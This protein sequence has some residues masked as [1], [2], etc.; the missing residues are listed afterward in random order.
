MDINTIVGR[1]L[2]KKREKR[3]M[4]QEEVAKLLEIPKQNVSAMESGKRT[5]SYA[6][7]GKICELFSITPECMFHLNGHTDM[8]EELLHEEITKMDKSGKA[9][10]YSHAVAI[11]AGKED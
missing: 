11:N 10:L 9:K 7:I 8:V 1:N 2:R 6:M 3:G 5:V 4:T